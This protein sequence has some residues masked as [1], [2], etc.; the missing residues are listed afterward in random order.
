MNYKYHKPKRRINLRINPSTN[1]IARLKYDSFLQVICNSVAFGFILATTR[2]VS[3]GN[4]YHALMEQAERIG[5]RTPPSMKL[6]MLGF[7][8]ILIGMLTLTLNIDLK[9]LVNK[10][11]SDRVLDVC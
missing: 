3:E 11:Q 2:T 8:R 5:V 10:K 1:R 6:A 7:G 4:Y 9:Y